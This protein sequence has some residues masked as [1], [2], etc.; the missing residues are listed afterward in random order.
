MVAA[1][2]RQAR[3][4][5]LRAGAVVF[6]LDDT[7]LRSREAKWDHH[8][9]VAA[10]VYDLEV[11]DDDLLRH[12]GRPFDELITT[13][14]RS[15]APLPEL[16]AANLALEPEFPKTAMAGAVDLVGHLLDRGIHVGVV[17]SANTEPAIADLTRIGFP[18]TRLLFVHGADITGA[19]KPDPA[20]FALA[21]GVLESRGVDA[22]RTVYVGDALM[23]MSAAL[24][25]GWDFVGVATGLVPGELFTRENIDWLDSLVEFTEVVSHGQA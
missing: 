4:K 15:A 7:L 25:A 3:R 11:T 17:T 23:D 24:G 12:W 16:R 8:K 1:R 13:L 2:V 5:I 9:A 21:R 6:D 19:H 14:Y 10:R 20:V 18:V 22:A